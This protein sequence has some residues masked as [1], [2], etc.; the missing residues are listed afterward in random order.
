MFICMFVCMVYVC[1][2]VSVCIM[3]ASVCVPVHMKVRGQWQVL[4]QPLPQ[5]IFWDTISLN[6]KLPDRLDH[7]ATSEIHL[8]LPP[9]SCCYR[10]ALPWW[11][12]HICWGSNLMS[13]H[14]QSKHFNQRLTSRATVKGST[15]CLWEAHELLSDKSCP[16][17]NTAPSI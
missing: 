7:G 4:L 10:H 11:L 15:D 14:L 8:S 3:H 12:L 2:P 17:R 1:I 5:L 16:F 13:S 6:L 9:Q